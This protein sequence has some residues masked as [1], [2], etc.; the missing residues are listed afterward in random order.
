MLS[1]SSISKIKLDGKELVEYRFVPISEAEKLLGYRLAR[2]LPK[3]VDAI[4]TGASIYLENGG[5]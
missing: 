5:L 2:R 4:K 3:C 1:E